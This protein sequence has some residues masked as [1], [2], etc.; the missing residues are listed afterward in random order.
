MA[1]PEFYND[2]V[3]DG[4]AGSMQSWFHP[5]RSF[6]TAEAVAVPYFVEVSIAGKYL[7]LKA[8]DEGGRVFDTL[9]LSKLNK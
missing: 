3:G 9:V 4:G 5:H 8:I 1:N 6:H 2:N 7:E